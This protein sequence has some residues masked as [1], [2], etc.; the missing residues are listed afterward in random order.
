M[1]AG[2]LFAA[3]GAM[4]GLGRIPGMGGLG[5]GIGLGIAAIVIFPIVYSVLGFVGGWVVASVYNWVARTVGGIVI[6]TR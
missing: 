3:M 4:G 2:L 5:M 6:E 1:I